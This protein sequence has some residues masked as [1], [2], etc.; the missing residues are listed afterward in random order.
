VIDMR[1]FHRSGRILIKITANG[2]GIDTVRVRADA[3]E[4]GLA[5]RVA[6]Q[7]AAVS[8]ARNRFPC[9]TCAG[10][11]GCCWMGSIRCSK[12]ICNNIDY[13]YLTFPRY[14]QF[15]FYSSP[16]VRFQLLIRSPQGHP[17]PFSQPNQA[18]LSSIV[19]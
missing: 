8:S 6:E 14:R 12:Y 18:F 3:A 16:R 13:L 4:R 9:C 7:G 11:P 17:A 15:A 2:P 10:S 1:A 19:L 5:M